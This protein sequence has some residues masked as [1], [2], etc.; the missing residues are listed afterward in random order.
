MYIYAI[1]G[2]LLAADNYKPFI[3]FGVS[4]LKYMP[5]YN[6]TFL[7]LQTKKKKI[8][9]AGCRTLLQTCVNRFLRSTQFT[10]DLTTPM[11]RA[12]AP[13]DHQHFLRSISA[14]ATH[15]IATV[16]TDRWVIAL[17][18]VRSVDAKPRIFRT[19]S[20]GRFQVHQILAAGRFVFGIVRFQLEVISAMKRKMVINLSAK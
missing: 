19:K 12:S 1:K 14:S 7:Y 17:A 3:F 11:E 20:R 16:H 9:D 10:F 4:D 13:L 5:S 8:Y 6:S 18:T 2:I 15:Q